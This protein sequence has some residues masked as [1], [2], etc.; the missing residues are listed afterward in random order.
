MFRQ[1]QQNYG[2]WLEYCPKK[3]KIYRL[4]DVEGKNKRIVIFL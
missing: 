4:R 3:Y 2:I 1:Q